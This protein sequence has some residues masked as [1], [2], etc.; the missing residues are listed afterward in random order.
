MSHEI[1]YEDLQRHW[2][3]GWG[4]RR[5]KLTGSFDVAML[6]SALPEGAVAVLVIGPSHEVRLLE[7]DKPL[8][9]QP[10]EQVV[11]FGPTGVEAQAPADN[12][13]N[14]AEKPRPLV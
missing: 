13:D 9:A 2:Y 11:W 4:F 7:A 5:T 8:R 14:A 3:R 12:G 10:G 6:Q 1:Q